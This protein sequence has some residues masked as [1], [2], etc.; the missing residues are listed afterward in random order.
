MD[1]VSMWSIVKHAWM[2]HF[3]TNVNCEEL[4]DMSDENTEDSSWSSFS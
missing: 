2:F 1:H 3:Q 4:L